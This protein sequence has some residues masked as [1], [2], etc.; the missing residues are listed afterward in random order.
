[1]VRAWEQCESLFSRLDIMTVFSSFMSGIKVLLYVIILLV[2]YVRNQNLLSKDYTHVHTFLKNKNRIFL[3]E[4]NYNLAVNFTL[5]R[6][7]KFV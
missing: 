1:M 7:E 4:L 2:G 6:F 5:F 3:L